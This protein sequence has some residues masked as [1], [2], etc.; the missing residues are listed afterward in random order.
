MKLAEGVRKYLQ[1]AGE[2]GAPAPLSRFGLSRDETERI[3]STWDEDYQI[4]RYMV[5][6][7]E[8]SGEPTRPRE[9]EAYLINGFEYSHVNFQADIQKLL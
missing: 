8:S 6:S 9:G 3:F 2:F 5:L 4:N 1:I 7:L